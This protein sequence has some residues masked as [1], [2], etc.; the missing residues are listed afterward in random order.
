MTMEFE[1]RGGAEIVHMP[2]LLVLANA[3]SIRAELVDRAS[4]GNPRMV[5]DLSRVEFADSSGLSAIL[6]CIGAARKRGGDV[7]L[8]SPSHR[9]R[10]LIELTRLDDVVLV[11]EDSDLAVARVTGRSAA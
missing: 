1:S 7:S 3:A 8:A 5:L 2:A 4:S 11:T 10:A 6:A 9:V